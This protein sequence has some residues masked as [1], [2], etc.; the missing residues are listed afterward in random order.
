MLNEELARGQGVPKDWLGE[1]YPRSE[2]VMKT[3][4]VHILEY[5]SDILVVAPNPVSPHAKSPDSTA[6]T[7]K[8]DKHHEAFTWNP[9][10]LA[11]RSAWTR[12]RTFSLIQAA[13]WYD[14][15]S[16]EEFTGVSH[17]RTPRRKP[18]RHV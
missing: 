3:V 2:S 16:E 4:A 1:S 6:S 14:D 11:P 17:V 13:L 15:P 8:E 10:D 9:P 12:E 7:T 18:R 5:L